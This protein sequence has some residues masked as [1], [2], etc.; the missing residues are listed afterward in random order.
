MVSSSKP[1]FSGQNTVSFIIPSLGLVAQSVERRLLRFSKWLP[2]RSVG[3]RKL[4]L[5]VAFHIVEFHY[6]R[7]ENYR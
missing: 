4:L 6:G 5:L 1:S 2:Q 3:D 7:L